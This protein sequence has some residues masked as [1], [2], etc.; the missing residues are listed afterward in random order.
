MNNFFSI[1]TDVSLNPV[2]KRGMGASLRLP[3]DYLDT[4]KDR[5]NKKEI[6]QNLRLRKFEN[7]SSTQ[8]EVETVLWAIENFLNQIKITENLKLDLYSDSQ[9]V[10]GLLER[11][12]GLN[13]KAFKNS[14]NE[15]LKHA[16][17][18]QKFYEYHDLLHFNVIKVTGHSPKDTHDTIHRVF[19][20]IDNEVRQEM[21][22]WNAVQ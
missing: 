21:R 2:L 20:F 4:E 9:C 6:I 11:R 16:A 5:L 13:K 3:S 1:F 8:L 22:K 19:S 10:C 7:T 18:Y 12:D 14:R 17:L 15:T